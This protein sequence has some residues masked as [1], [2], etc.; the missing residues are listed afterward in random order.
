MLSLDSGEI[1]AIPASFS[2]VVF[3]TCDLTNACPATVS[4]CALLHFG[5]ITNAWQCVLEAWIAHRK[6]DNLHLPFRAA[7][8]WTFMYA[9][10]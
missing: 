2:C 9:W 1:V 10:Q 4:R 5:G 7:S 6:E 8:E 3:E